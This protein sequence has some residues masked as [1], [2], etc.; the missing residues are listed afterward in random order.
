MKKWFK[1]HSLTL[2]VPFLFIFV[3]CASH[4]KINESEYYCENKNNDVASV[5]L[6]LFKSE[7]FEFSLH[8][9]NEREPLVYNGT[10]IKRRNKYE[11]YFSPKQEIQVQI[12]RIFKDNNAV[13]VTDNKVII[14]GEDN[15]ITI[16]DGLPCFVKN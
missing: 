13:Q 5:F 14:N 11:L 16:W 10:W 1:I 2:L 8:L 12:K 3:G 9:V 7:K 6:K 15:Q 4:K